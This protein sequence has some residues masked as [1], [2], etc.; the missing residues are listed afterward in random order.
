MEKLEQFETCSPPTDGARVN[1]VVL[2]SGS[3]ITAGRSEFEFQL[4]AGEVSE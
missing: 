4:Q 1:E 3:K 2:Q